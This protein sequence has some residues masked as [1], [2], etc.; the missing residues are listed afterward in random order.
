MVPNGLTITLV[1]PHYPVNL[2]HIA[3]LAKN[4]GVSK[5]YLIDPKVDISTALVYASHAADVLYNAERIDFNELRKRHELLI[6]TTARRAYNERNVIRA[7]IRPEKVVHYVH[8]TR[9]SSLVF[10]RDTIGLTNEEIRLCDFVTTIDTGTSYR[11]L[12]VSHAAAILL[13]LISTNRSER[14]RT[15]SRILR[16]VFVENLCQLANA[17]G[18]AEYKV[19]KLSVMAKRIAINSRMSE[20]EMSL[21]VGILRK[22][23][24]MLKKTRDHESSKT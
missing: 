6:A 15:P 7:C 14:F 23:T 16:E 11:T 13:Y 4:F 21:I 20:K 24:F 1:Q 10:G 5:L 12:N 8:S 18:L 17:S 9:S 2:G 3:R 22:A 19:R